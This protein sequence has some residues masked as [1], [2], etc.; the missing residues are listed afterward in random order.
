MTK[1]IQYIG[2]PGF[3]LL[4]LFPLLKTKTNQHASRTA[5]YPLSSRLRARLEIDI[6]IK[7]PLN[8]KWT[9]HSKHKES[10]FGLAIIAFKI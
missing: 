4:A 5:V 9:M 6:E 8:F 7:V 10:L 2:L 3:N 1:P